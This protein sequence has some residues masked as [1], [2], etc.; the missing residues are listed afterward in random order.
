[1]V[2]RWQKTTQQQL[3]E[4]QAAMPSLKEQE[5]RA[6][7]ERMAA[8]VEIERRRQEALAQA[9]ESR[10]QRDRQLFLVAGLAAVLLVVIAILALLLA[11]GG[12]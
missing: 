3:Y 11:S 7:Q 2:R 6:S 8:F 5:E 9:R 1:M 10:R 12:S 4:R